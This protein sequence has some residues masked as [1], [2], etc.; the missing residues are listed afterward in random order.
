M[1]VRSYGFMRTPWPHAHRERL[2]AGV[3]LHFFAP[4]EFPPAIAPK[5]PFC[6]IVSKCPR[7][8][9]CFRIFLAFFPV[10]GGFTTEAQEVEAPEVRLVPQGREVRPASAPHP[11][12]A[13]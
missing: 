11:A 10:T 8:D 4:V 5:N 2:A 1:E 13:G 3:A 7:I 9:P 6:R 12:G